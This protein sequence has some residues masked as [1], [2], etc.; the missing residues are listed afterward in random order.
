MPKD[1][2]GRPLAK[3]RRDPVSLTNYREKNREL[4]GALINY[5]RLLKTYELT[6]VCSFY[7]YLYS[8]NQNSDVYETTGKLKND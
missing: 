7:L 2:T 6:S 1:I 3:S 8:N 4:K 5:K